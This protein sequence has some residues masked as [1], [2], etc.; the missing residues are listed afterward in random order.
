M[1]L[2]PEERQKIYLAEKARLEIRQ[3]LDASA[4]A[5]AARPTPV[6]V[7][8]PSPASKKVST[9]VVI[10]WSILSFAALMVI[11]S[12]IVENSKLATPNPAQASQ[13]DQTVHTGNPAHDR[14]VA[15]GSSAQASLLGQIAGEECGGVSAFY[16]GMDKETNVFWSVRCA[17]SKS[18]QIQIQPN[19]TGST[20]IMDCAV[21]KA[22]ADVD[23]F[24]KF[25]AQSHHVRTKKQI[26][27]DID[28]LPPALK[29]QMVGQLEDN[30]GDH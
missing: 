10:G 26:K 27:A 17:N 9:G 12:S 1:E 20:R 8:Q 5:V 22:V 21:L 15:L 14:L 18:Y 4:A 19:A 13:D 23:C 3:Q 6:L 30:L 24:V 25:D 2:T 29:K 16:M 28:R 7:P 11:I